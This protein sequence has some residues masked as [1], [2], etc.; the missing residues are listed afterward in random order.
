[1]SRMVTWI[2]VAAMAVWV[3][4]AFAAKQAVEIEDAELD[5]ITAAG[6]PTVLKSGD[7]SPVVHSDEAQFNLSFDAPEVQ[8]GLRAL[9]IQNVVGELQLLV[10][11]NVLSAIAK[12][13]A[14][15]QRNFS[16]QS[17][18]GTLPEFAT[19]EGVKAEP[20]PA[21]TTDCQNG[22]VNVAVADA[23]PGEISKPASA[24]GDLIIETGDGSPIVNTD[25]PLFNLD[26]AVSRAQADLAAL[27]ITNMV[28]RAQVALN[29]NI[30]AATLSLVPDPDQN[31]SE[32][33]GGDIG[34]CLGAACAG[35]IKQV[36][37]G[38]QFR[39]TPLVG[40]TNV[41]TLFKLDVTHQNQ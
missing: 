41:N 9:T 28:G 34:S 33:I 21:C 3:P 16:L 5:T 14:T 26:F 27:F 13:A 31:F 10:D 1:M 19:V 4:S 39:G 22:A 25:E 2:L 23:V 32:P 12:V 30:A 8:S 35:V 37:T 11:L 38:L 18:G 24:S 20:F 17:W 36:N 15:D 29:L 40:A 7:G 6:Q